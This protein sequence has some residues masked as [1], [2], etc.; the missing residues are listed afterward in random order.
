MLTRRQRQPKSLHAAELD[1]YKS[2]QPTRQPWLGG[3]CI[4]EG[5]GASVLE[6]RNMP[7]VRVGAYAV[8]ARQPQ[9]EDYTA[10]AMRRIADLGHAAIACH[11]N[12]TVAKKCRVKERTPKGRRRRRTVV[13]QFE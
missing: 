4:P 10:I 6:E 8:H 3:L 11:G 9:L 2:G 13:T 7:S 1:K 12:A 5:D